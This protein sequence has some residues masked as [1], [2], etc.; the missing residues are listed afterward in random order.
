MFICPA[1]VTKCIACHITELIT[2]WLAGCCSCSLSKVTEFGKDS[3]KV[4]LTQSYF[5]DDK[6]ITPVFTNVGQKS[7]KYLEQFLQFFPVLK[8]VFIYFTIS[9]VSEDRGWKT[10]V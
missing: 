1:E 3:T 2:L 8:I 4:F 7:L 6:N 9:R 10:V 5:S